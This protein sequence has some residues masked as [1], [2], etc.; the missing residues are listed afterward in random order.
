MYSYVIGIAA[1]IFAILAS[2]S[3]WVIVSNDTWFKENIPHDAISPIVF[4]MLYGILVVLLVPTVYISALTLPLTVG[5]FTVLTVLFLITVSFIILWL[6]YL[7][8]IHD[9]RL[10]YIF[11]LV[12][13]IASV[14]FTF[15]LFNTRMCIECTNAYL[16]LGLSIGSNIWLG[17]CFYLT[18]SMQH[19]SN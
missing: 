17:Y 13:F 2:I 1:F 14:I 18:Y 7:F 6:I 16:T 3:I 9:I 12:A 8:H 10:A 15:Y 19:N 4:Y 5:M 11:I